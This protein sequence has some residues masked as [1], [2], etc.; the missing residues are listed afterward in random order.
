MR[1]PGRLS[2]VLAACLAV[3]VGGAQE[4]GKGPQVS[5]RVPAA[6]SVEGIQINRMLSGPFG[7]DASSITPAPNMQRYVYRCVG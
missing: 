2:G 7:G 1:L 5:I 3:A 6:A 4:A